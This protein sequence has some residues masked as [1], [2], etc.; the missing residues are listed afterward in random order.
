MIG[1]VLANR[2]CVVK[3]ICRNNVRKLDI[4]GDGIMV[5]QAAMF[6][7]GVEEE[8][9]VIDP[10]T[11]ELSADVKRIFPRAQELVGT[12]V[13]Y[14]LMQSQIE[15]ATPICHTLADVQR[16]LVRLRNGIILA[17]E[18]TGARIAA[19]GTH[20]FSRWQDQVIIPKEHYQL[21]VDTHRQMILEQVI[22]GYHVHVGVPDRE[23]VCIS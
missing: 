15:I 22:F 5:Q 9:Q 13:Q 19:S 16:E 18:H 12:A 21:L 14:E 7:I 17:A 11:R 1:V 23:A 8:Y 2:M 3:N 20:P 6:T 10:Q 4:K